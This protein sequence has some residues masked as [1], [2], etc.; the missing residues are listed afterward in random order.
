MHQGGVVPL[1]G[2]Y[3]LGLPFMRTRKSTLID[4]VGDD[5]AFIAAHL[6]AGL[7]KLAA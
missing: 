1:P 6:H 7:D 2:L 5:A 3:T 4:G